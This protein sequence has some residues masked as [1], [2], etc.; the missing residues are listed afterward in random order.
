MFASD[1]VRE[2]RRLLFTSSFLVVVGIVLNRLNVAVTGIE[3]ATGVRYM[4]SLGEISISVFLTAAGF[5][6]FGVI[7]KFAPVFPEKKGLQIKEA[8]KEAFID[9]RVS[10]PGVSP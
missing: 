6:A 8:E 1:R 3:S 5:I 4:P 10:E 7:A 9:P 2:S